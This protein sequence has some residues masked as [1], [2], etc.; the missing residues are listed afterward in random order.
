MLQKNNFV[1]IEFTG[2]VKDGE[3]FDTNIKSEAV[4]MELEIE[5]RPLTICLGQNMILPAIDDFLIGK[6]IGKHSIELLPEKAFGMRDKSLIKTVPLKMFIE[7]QIMPRPGMMFNFDNAIG[8]ISS[9]SGGR[10]I[11]DFNNPLANKTVVYEIN[12]KR[13]LEDN[14]EKVDSLMNFFFRRKFEFKI[15]GSELIVDA[16][17]KLKPF[18]EAFKE[19][20]KEILNLDMKINE[21]EEKIITPENK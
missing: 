3:L 19:R 7:K 15:N 20:F 10:V 8:K 13:V 12:V 21:V 4:K 11:V 16:D 18:L 1:E 5:E 6:E 17:K 14:K 2:K 9:V